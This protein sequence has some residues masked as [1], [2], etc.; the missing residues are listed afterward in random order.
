MQIICSVSSFNVAFIRLH[1]DEYWLCIFHTGA[2]YCKFYLL[3]F[4]VLC[5]C[6]TSTVSGVSSLHQY[7]LIWERFNDF[8]IYSYFICIRLLF[9]V[10]NMPKRLITIPTTLR[11][12]ANHQIVIPNWYAICFLSRWSL[13][14]ISSPMK[15][16]VTF[17]LACLAMVNF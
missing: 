14:S 16:K 12:G 13:P 6:G 5:G 11:K 4:R 2:V 8:N 3:F 15:Q 1:L 9:V 7:R 10:S 17:V